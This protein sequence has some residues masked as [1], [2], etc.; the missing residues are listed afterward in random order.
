MLK[1]KQKKLDKNNNGRIDAEDFKL[2]KGSKKGM[3]MGGMMYADDGA[4]V[5]YY[6]N[7][8]KVDKKNLD[9]AGKGVGELVERIMMPPAAAI[10]DTG[11]AYKEFKK[12]QK[13]KQNKKD[14]QQIEAK[15]GKM[16]RMKS[17]GMNSDRMTAR[18]IEAASARLATSAIRNKYRTAQLE[19]ALRQNPKNP[20]RLTRK[21]IEKASSAVGKRKGGMLKAKKGKYLDKYERGLDFHPDPLVRS[22]KMS[23]DTYDSVSKGMDLGLGALGVLGTGVVGFAANEARKAR[24]KADKRKKM[25]KEYI[26]SKGSMT[27]GSFRVGGLSKQR[28]DSISAHKNRQ[29]KMKKEKQQEEN[30]RKTEISPMGAKTGKSVDMKELFKTIGKLPLSKK[31]MEDV[32]RGQKNPSSVL[33]K[34]KGGMLKAKTGKSVDTIKITPTIK[35]KPLK[36]RPFIKSKFDSGVRSRDYKFSKK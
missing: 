21:D 24:K 26:K 22:G 14:V 2:L 32:K 20:D 3:R 9:R 11:K 36:A 13:R 27:Q 34:A 25:K 8:P 5:D 33:K 31:A 19:K 16:V 29:A 30:I 17:G 7:T 12:M 10:R 23:R 1:G 4:F 35:G 15:K 6:S 18:D 28:L